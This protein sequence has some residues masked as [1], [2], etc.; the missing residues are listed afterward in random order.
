MPQYRGMPEW[1]DGS[2]VGKHPHSCR[3]RGIELGVSE[4]EIWKGENI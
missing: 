3:G 2:G 1:E 4:G